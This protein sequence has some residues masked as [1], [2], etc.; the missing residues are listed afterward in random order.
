MQIKYVLVL[1][2]NLFVA[3]IY[4]EIL[5][6]TISI[7][8]THPIVQMPSTGCFNCIASLCD[9]DFN[10]IGVHVNYKLKNEITFCLLPLSYFVDSLTL[11]CS[12]PG[13]IIEFK[14]DKDVLRLKLDD[15]F[16]NFEQQFWQWNQEQF[17][18]NK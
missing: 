10:N 14:R 13:D 2:F 18:S 5:Y 4:S 6:G 3:N 8:G 9:L 17:K 11:E 1:F 12:K 15:S 16:K 7:P